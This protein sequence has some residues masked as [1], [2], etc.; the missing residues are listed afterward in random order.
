MNRITNRWLWLA[1]T[2]LALTLLPGLAQGKRS[3]KRLG[4]PAFRQAVATRLKAIDRAK[5]VQRDA[6]IK[7][8]VTDIA[9]LQGAIFERKVGGESKMTSAARAMRPKSQRSGGFVP[10]PFVKEGQTLRWM[11]SDSHNKRNCSVGVTR[12]EGDTETYRGVQF[13]RRGANTMQTGIAVKLGGKDVQLSQ[14]SR[15]LQVVFKHNYRTDGLKTEA[16]RYNK[17]G[18][19]VESSLWYRDGVVTETAKGLEVHT[20]E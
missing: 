6:L 11:A 9:P 1:A 4:G 15:G 13:S 18:Q 7:R 19:W 14:T 17:R 5:P 20:F 10:R 12:R 3:L 8:L 2:L 16:F